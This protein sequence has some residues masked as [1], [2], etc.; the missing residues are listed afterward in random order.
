MR[1][2]KENAVVNE[3]VEN[4]IKNAFFM[5]HGDSYTACLQVSLLNGIR[6][7]KNQLK[8]QRMADQR[9]AVLSL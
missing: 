2:T 3:T 6:G 1:I 4:K 7:L 9:P 8:H 5:T